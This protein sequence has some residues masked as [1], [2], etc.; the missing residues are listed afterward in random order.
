MSEKITFAE[1]IESIAEETDHSKQFTHDFLKDFVNVINGGLEE[2]GKANIAG[3]GKFKLRRMDEREGYNPQTREK[4]TI[5]AHNKIVF[6]PYKDLR[7]LVNAPYANMEPV[8][9]EDK[10]EDTSTD[11]SAIEPENKNNSAG[12]ASNPDDAIPFTEDTPDSESFRTDS[13]EEDFIPTAPP[14]SH[15][16]DDENTGDDNNTDNSNDILSFDFSL[17]DPKNSDQ[18][19]SEISNNNSGDIVEF[20][21]TEPDQDGTEDQP[22]DEFIGIDGESDKSQK[23]SVEDS[24][25]QPQESDSDKIQESGNESEKDDPLPEKN[26]STEVEPVNETEV[27][28]EN[29]NSE[30]EVLADEVDKLEHTIQDLKKDQS[31]ENKNNQKAPP[32][33]SQKTESKSKKPILYNVAAT[34]ILLL[35]TGGAWYYNTI[36]PVNIPLISSN[37]TATTVADQKAMRQKQTENDK[38]KPATSTDQ[39]SVSSSSSKTPQ[40]RSSELSQQN[41]SAA[42]TIEKGQTLWSLAEEK[43]GNPRLWPWIYGKN[44]SLEDPDIIYAGHSLSV[45]LPSGPQNSLNAS[46]SIGV[47]RGFIATYKWYKNNRASKAKSHLWAAKLYHK[48]IQQLADIPIDKADLSYANRAR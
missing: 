20:S 28:I 6:K 21:S 23:L 38:A 40:N 41:N 33:L 31:D 36:S 30:E 3:F 42:I 46:D 29:A 25:D 39:S 44:G 7:E 32:P 22:F 2:D 27:T 47:A 1:L 35:I 26:T 48:N 34:I 17:D 43:Y 15:Q 18:E 13:K 12:K 8:L 9:I 24:T 45:P 4:M 10:T 16:Y 19:D 37:K 5:P 14:T 11:T